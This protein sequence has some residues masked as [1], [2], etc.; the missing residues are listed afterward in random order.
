MIA[1]TK[2]L[3]V[4][5]GRCV[6]AIIIIELKPHFPAC[7]NLFLL[8][9]RRSKSWKVSVFRRLRVPLSLSK[10]TSTLAYTATLR[11]SSKTRVLLPNPSQDLSFSL[12]RQYLHS[13][14]LHPPAIL[15]YTSVLHGAFDLPRHAFR[16][17]ALKMYARPPCAP[18]AG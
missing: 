3:Y 2:S 11:Y 12:P 5:K 6:L 17:H 10:R 4:Y 18:Y 15:Q 7:L 9:V 16:L 8:P 14:D 13:T 1:F